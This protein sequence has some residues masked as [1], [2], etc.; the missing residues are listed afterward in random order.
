MRRRAVSK[1]REMCKEAIPRANSTFRDKISSL[2]HPEQ[3]KSCIVVPPN[4]CL[5]PTVKVSASPAECIVNVREP[6]LEK[7]RNLKLNQLL[8]LFCG[9][10]RPT[11]FATWFAAHL[12]SSRPSFFFLLACQAS[13]ASCV[14]TP[15]LQEIR[16]SICGSEEN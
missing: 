16:L 9:H 7:S 3:T 14:T 8:L 12:I 13:P 6:S 1:E 11:L 4:L 10:I 5:P 15:H 2:P